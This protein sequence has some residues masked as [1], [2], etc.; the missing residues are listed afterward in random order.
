MSELNYQD[1]DF[2][3][4]DFDDQLA[5]RIDYIR[6]NHSN[7]PVRLC[8]NP[9]VDSGLFAVSII[10]D[11]DINNI[12]L[13]DVL[14][15]ILNIDGQQ[16]QGK[17]FTRRN[18]RS[19]AI[20][21]VLL[22][23]PMGQPAYGST[24]KKKKG[25]YSAPSK[26]EPSVLQ[27]RIYITYLIEFLLSYARDQEIEDQVHQC[28]IC[29]N[30]TDFDFTDLETTLKILISQKDLSKQDEFGGGPTRTWFPLVGSTSS[31]QALPGF[32]EFNII[33]GKCLTLA[34]FLP[35]I[36]DLQNGM[37]TIYQ[38]SNLKLAKE[39]YRANLKTF[40]EM[41]TN[42]PSDE[43]LDVIG[44]GKSDYYI[45]NLLRIIRENED[46]LSH[47]NLTLWRYDNYGTDPQLDYV[48]LP[49]RT[50]RFLY[51]L[52]TKY[53]AGKIIKNFIRF[54]EEQ[55]IYS[56][57]R[58]FNC[59][60]ARKDYFLFYPNTKY[61]I[62]EFFEP[63]NWQVLY[64]LYQ[65]YIMSWNTQALTTVKTI[66]RYLKQKFE[67][68]DEELIRILSSRDNSTIRKFLIPYILESLGEGIITTEE[69]VNLF[70]T[71]KDLEES[72]NPWKLFR[73]FLHPKL[74]IQDIDLSYQKQDHELSDERKEALELINLVATSTI[75]RQKNRSSFD[76]NNYINTLSAYR[77]NQF[78]DDYV[79]TA[80][81][82]TYLT[83]EYLEDLQ[84]QLYRSEIRLYFRIFSIQSY[85]VSGHISTVLTREKMIEES[86]L[87]PLLADVLIEYIEHRIKD[88][89]ENRIFSELDHDLK[90][91]NYSA[92]QFFYVLLKFVEENV[93]ED[94]VDLTGFDEYHYYGYELEYQAHRRRVRGSSK[95]KP[96]FSWRRFRQKLRLFIAQY[97]QIRNPTLE[98]Q[99]EVEKE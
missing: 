37:L 1:Y 77:F 18:A 57:R 20:Y 10:Q 22:N 36:S 54:E 47:S 16:S 80:Y 79:Q 4:D 2:F 75:D 82:H 30:Y 6:S 13:G 43:K 72:H 63:E 90:Y 44:K 38:S 85:S 41:H 73:F 95:R 45:N 98:Q 68:D 83:W 92:K 53:N 49:N 14:E 39:F 27:E 69:L 67:E 60:E 35:Q 31:I 94:K 91:E 62:S 46:E 61:D 19:S 8:G 78:I 74:E 9:F 50:I 70:E 34:Q 71:H 87:A 26:A 76:L 3:S 42:T 96:Q 24:S 48:H 29:G 81:D 93:D 25:V 55:S 21:K 58:F 12:T 65:T 32:A 99:I 86:G 28:V 51:L 97:R 5:E 88:I 52:D 40:N 66:A 23:N 64:E 17:A 15:T 33:C 56:S 89:G 11:K 84:N 7:L 59:I